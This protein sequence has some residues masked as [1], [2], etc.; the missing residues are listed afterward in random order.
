VKAAPLTA[1]VDAFV[2][3]GCDGLKMID[4]PTARRVMNVPV[5]DAYYADY[6]ARVEELKLPIVWHVNDPEEFWEP[7]KL[8][9]WARQL[10]WGYGPDEVKKEALYAEVEVVLARHPKLCA[11]FPHFYFLSADLPRAGRFLD[12]HPS[13][14]FDLAPGIEFLYNMSHDLD[15][16]RAFFVRYADR[17]IFGTDLAS[18]QT[19][20]EGRFRAG[21][22]YRWLETED[23]FRVPS[24]VDFLL[25]QPQDGLIRGLALPDD[26]L[27]K[28]Y[29]GNFTRLAGACPKPLNLGLAA[30]ELER[31]AAIAQAMSGKPAA[32]TEAGRAAKILAG[33]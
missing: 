27:A 30:E 19:V 5:T 15:A 31:E 22:V 6:W 23:T 4:K 7:A 32:E 24:G 2:A 29:G 16:T 25:G 18:R 10:G 21:I 3:A 8:P 11:I 20:E 9:A 1:Q 28:L 26:V 17:I 14:S 13:V 33:G 12:A